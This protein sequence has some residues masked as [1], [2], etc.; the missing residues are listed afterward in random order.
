[1]KFWLPGILWLLLPFA[2][3]AQ[4]YRVVYSPSLK[5]E[6]FIDNVE[7]NA[8]ANWCQ[9]RLPL[10]IVSDENQNTDVLATFLPRVGILLEKQCSH[11]AE[12][13]WQM[14]N[15]QGKELA[16]GNATRNNNW[17]PVFTAPEKNTLHED[18]A[19]RRAYPADTTPLPRFELPNGCHFRTWWHAK[20]QSLFIPDNQML[21]CSAEGWL[22]GNTQIQLQQE[23]KSHSWPVT[24]YQGYPLAN[25]RLTDQML[26]IITVNNQR[27]VVSTPENND[28]WLLL[29]FDPVSQSW[30]FSGTL[31]LKMEKNTAQDN[32]ALEKRVNAVKQHWSPYLQPQQKINILLIDY[33]YPDLI[34]PA[35]GA[36]RTIN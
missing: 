36:Y 22:N 28:S 4:D 7:G 17:L 8:P 21:T 29:P 6:V 10:R 35:I 13:P 1:M 3:N 9:Q 2:V 25:L 31:L 15:K 16:N 34:D 23:G 26:T 11:L 18:T 30:L 20:S 12:L 14:T 5:L 33:L 24:F 32:E 27:M 19:A